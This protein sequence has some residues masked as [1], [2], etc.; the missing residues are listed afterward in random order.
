MTG[1]DRARQVIEQNIA[2]VRMLAED[3]LQN[4]S[5][6]ADE[7]KALLTRAGARM[8]TGEAVGV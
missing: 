4:E 2:S 7:I 6:E 8:E 5:L 3:L 1:Y